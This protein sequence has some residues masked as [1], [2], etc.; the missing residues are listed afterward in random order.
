MPYLNIIFHNIQHGG[1][2]VNQAV[3]RANYT[4]NFV[5]QMNVYQTHL[6]PGMVGNA[7]GAPAGAWGNSVTGANAAGIFLCESHDYNHADY[8]HWQAAPSAIPVF[9]GFPGNALNPPVAGNFINSGYTPFGPL[10]LLCAYFEGANENAV[11]APVPPQYP[12]GPAPWAFW[13]GSANHAHRCIGTGAAQLFNGNKPPGSDRYG[14]LF[15][16][17]RRHYPAPA[18]RIL[19]LFVHVKNTAADPGT[20]IAALCNR[21]PNAIVFGDLNLNL[22]HQLKHESLS[23]AVSNTHTILAI[24]TPGGGFYYTR[25]NAAGAGRSCLDYALVP[26]NHVN[27]VELWAH[28]PAAGVATLSTNNSDHSVMMLR[29]RCT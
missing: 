24:Q 5:G 28:Q 20:Q 21:F 6:G 29:I 8:N 11:G 1:M 10:N 15:Q 14:I 22:R 12:S 2:R 13:M 3:S 17:Y 16:V 18:D 9:P 23:A 19:G 25:Y 27:D 26:N 4:T 7:G